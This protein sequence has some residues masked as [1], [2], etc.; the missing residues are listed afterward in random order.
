[1]ANA[2][3]TKVDKRKTEKILNARGHFSLK[4]LRLK[5]ALNKRGMRYI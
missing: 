1:M 4:L 3:T 5:M 2:S